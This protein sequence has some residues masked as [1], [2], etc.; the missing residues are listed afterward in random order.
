MAA[1]TPTAPNWPVDMITGPGNIYVT[2]AKRICRSLVGIDAGPAPP[3]S[4][5]WPTT[6]PTR[7]AAA[8]LISQ[9]EHDEMAASVLVTDRP[10][11]PRRRRRTDRP[12]GD[13]R[14]PSARHHGPVRPSSRPP[15]S[16]TT[17]TP[18]TGGQRLRGRAPGIQTVDAA[19]RRQPDPF[20]E[21]FS[22]APTRRSAWVTTARAQP[23][24]ADCGCARHSNGLSVQTFL[25]ASTSSTTTRPR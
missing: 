11:W 24:A 18:G 17:S 20:V 8:D 23:R 14:A 1:P 19:C 10:R 16:S 12:A 22:S 21:P 13:H 4:R 15:C 7:R 2:A 25:R 6:P 9:A 5:S 3:R